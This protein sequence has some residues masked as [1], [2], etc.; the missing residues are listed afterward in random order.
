ME[1]GRHLVPSGVEPVD[2]LSGGLESGKLYLV[3]GEG[4]ALEALRQ[5]VAQNGWAVEIAQHLQTVQLDA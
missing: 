4:P 1:K 3:H 5:R 2:K